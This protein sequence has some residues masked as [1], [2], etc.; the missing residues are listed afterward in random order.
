[1][2]ERR[3]VQIPAGYEDE[4]HQLGDDGADDDDYRCLRLENSMWQCKEMNEEFFPKS[5]KKK[6]KISEMNPKQAKW[7]RAKNRILR[8][9]LIKLHAKRLT[10]KRL[11]QFS[12]KIQYAARP[13][14]A[15]A[16]ARALLRD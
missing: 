15:N 4:Y 12:G 2:S 6:K 8:D 3:V 7:H 1:M 13:S 10:T 11:F 9:V 14:D 16:F 5:K